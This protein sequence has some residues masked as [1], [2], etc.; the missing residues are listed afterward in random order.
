MASRSKKRKGPAGK[1]KDIVTDAD[2]QRELVA[3]GERLVV[4]NFS[5]A[6][7]DWCSLNRTFLRFPLI[8]FGSSCNGAEMRLCLFLFEPGVPLARR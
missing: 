3:A 8:R 2:F 1:V 6:W 7:Y 5:A 4:A